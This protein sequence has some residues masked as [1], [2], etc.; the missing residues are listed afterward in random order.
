MM[1]KSKLKCPRLFMV[2]ELN[3]TLVME[4]VD[5]KQVKLVLNDGN[6]E[7]IAALIGRDLTI[8]H[9]DDCIHGDLTTSNILFDG[10]LIWLDFGLSQISN[11]VEDKAVDLY[12]LTRFVY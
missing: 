7:E 3:M 8:F 12:V 6:L 9:G 4:F 1:A 5:A 11:S 2:D 10:E